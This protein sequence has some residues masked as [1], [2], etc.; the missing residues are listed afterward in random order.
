MTR[1]ARAPGYCVWLV[2]AGGAIWVAAAV[3][4]SLLIVSCFTC[5]SVVLAPGISASGYPLAALRDLAWG[6]L[7]A[8]VYV[9]T[10]GLLA[11]AIGLTAFRHR[12][13]W[14]W[15]AIAVFVLAGVLTGLLDYLSWGGWYTFLLFGLPAMLGLVLSAP[16]FFAGPSDRPDPL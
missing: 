3:L 9:G 14:A 10:V 5:S 7:Y 15:Y 1:A 8:D 12:Q 16:T 2:V 6:D 11:A 13:R 4:Y